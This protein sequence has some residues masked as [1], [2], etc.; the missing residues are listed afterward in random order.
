MATPTQKAIRT[1]RRLMCDAA[2]GLPASIA[3]MRSSPEEAEAAIEERQLGTLQAPSE[4]HDKT[5]KTAY[6]AYQVYV[7]RVRNKM[8]EKFRRFSGTVEVVV[9]VRMSQDRLEGLTERVQ[10]FADAVTDVVERN[11]GCV[12]EGVYLPGTYEV[13]FEPVKKGGLNVMQTARVKC[14]L[15]V[16]RG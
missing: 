8:T 16:S 15:E 9:E 10:F 3:M 7:E 11:R 13:S 2:D 12:E 14:E 6:P 5:G 4:L 1:V